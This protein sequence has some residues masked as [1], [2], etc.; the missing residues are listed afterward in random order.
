M[1]VIIYMVT[2]KT[3]TDCKARYEQE[4]TQCSYNTDA[5]PIYVH[6]VKAWLQRLCTQENILPWG[7][8]GKRMLE[9]AA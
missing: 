8:I 7:S 2:L 1:C 6:S 3:G 4:I 9:N 5:F